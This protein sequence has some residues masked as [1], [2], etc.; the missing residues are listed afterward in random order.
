[1]ERPARLIPSKPR[2]G[3]F[4]AWTIHNRKH[5]RFQIRT[6]LTP[7]TVTEPIANT[8]R[9]VTRYFHGYNTVALPRIEAQFGKD[10]FAE[11]ATE[12]QT[13]YKGDAASS[14]AISQTR[15]HLVTGRLLSSLLVSNDCGSWLP[16]C[17]P[18]TKD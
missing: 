18:L 13:A 5:A 1:V 11:N 7:N 10:I 2:R 16:R 6:G 4:P 14:E 12:A 9:G 17:S 3:R 15:E 8:P